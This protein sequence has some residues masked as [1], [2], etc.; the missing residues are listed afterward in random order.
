MSLCDTR[1]NVASPIWCN[2]LV[3]VAAPPQQR[4][5]AGQQLADAERLGDVVVGAELEAADDFFFLSLGGEHDDRQ[6]E[7][8]ARGRGGRFRSR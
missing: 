1:S 5:H 6:V 2:G 8:R 3:V 7:L 4:L